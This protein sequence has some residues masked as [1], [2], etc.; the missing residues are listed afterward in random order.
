[1]AGIEF[2]RQAFVNPTEQPHRATP[3]IGGFLLLLVAIGAI[4]FVGYKILMSSS[5]TGNSQNANLA[6]I[7]DQLNQI[8]KRLDQ[9]EKHHKVAAEPA[10]SPDKTDDARSASIPASRPSRP[11]YRIMPAPA[12]TTHPAAAT[13]SSSDPRIPGIE[14]GLGTLQN[15]STANHEAWEATTNRLADVVGEVGSQHG[16]IVQTREALNQLLARS[17]RTAIRF[18]LR[19]GLKEQPVGPIYLGLKS[20]D[21]KNRRYSVC[22]YLQDKCTELKDRVL[23]EVVEISLSSDQVPL[24]LVATQIGRNQIVGFLAVPHEKNTP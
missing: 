3:P 1:M 6:Q 15:D 11:V 12:Q 19:R 20:A 16:E 5:V 17:E 2:D 22:V 7:Q 23:D 13:I 21:P 14:R 24:E 10:P 18:E 8:E 4:G 9:L